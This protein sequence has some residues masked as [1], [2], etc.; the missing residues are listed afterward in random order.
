MEK[1][2]KERD[3]EEDDEDCGDTEKNRREG[4]EKCK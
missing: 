4:E 1:E 2:T 3:E